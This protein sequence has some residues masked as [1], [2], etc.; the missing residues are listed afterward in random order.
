MTATFLFVNCF[1]I[2]P[3]LII[4]PLSKIARDR[5]LLA[6]GLFLEMAGLV[7][8]SY[9]PANL[10]TVIVGY[11]LSLKASVFVLTIAF[12]LYS[13]ILRSRTTPTLIG[14]LSTAWGAGPAL[15][16]LLG[17]TV[18]YPLF[19]HWVFLTFAVGAMAAFAVSVLPHVWRWF[20]PYGLEH[21]QRFKM[22]HSVIA[23]PSQHWPQGESHPRAPERPAR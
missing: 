21:R 9:S 18:L 12:G 13:K 23:Q 16:A 6:L 19:N 8:Y 14:A 1:A 20:E 17:G 11:A 22:M 15:G 3:S 5:T 10:W 7:I 2:L 4:P